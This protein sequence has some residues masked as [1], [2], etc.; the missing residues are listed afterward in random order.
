M[1]A[2]ND[3]VLRP[4]RPEDLPEVLTVLE[5]SEPPCVRRGGGSS[6]AAESFPRYGFRRIETVRG[7]RS[8]SSPAEF[9]DLCPA[10]S[11]VVRRSIG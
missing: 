5:G 6:G 10:S 11:T 9:A 1:P 8:G 4:M 2:A 3:V 7:C